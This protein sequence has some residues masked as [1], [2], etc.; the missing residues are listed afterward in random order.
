[1]A[2][3]DKLYHIP[4]RMQADELEIGRHVI[5]AA[6]QAGI[7]LFVYHSV[8]HP[9][10]EE[11]VF[12]WEKMK[13]ELALIKSGLNFV[14]IQPTNYMQ[15]IVWTWQ[16]IVEQGIYTLPYSADAPLTWVD[17]SDVAEAVAN[18]LTEEGHEGAVYELSG[19]D[20]AL[21]RHQVCEMAGRVLGREVRAEAES[22]EDYLSKPRFKDRDPAEMNLLRTM[23]QFYDQYG[24]KCGNP[25][26][27][28]MLLRRPSTDYETC[29]RRIVAESWTWPK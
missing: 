13:V 27:L 1:M 10:I 29:L 14:L 4:P 6:K 11:I 3:V 17:L 26:V 7:R 2:G 19:P 16:L 8:V 20:G 5:R 22:I 21:T 25:R 18:V 23:F 15:N 12:H 24:L 9:A 28:E